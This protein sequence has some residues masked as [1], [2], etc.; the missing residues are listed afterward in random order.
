M[1]VSFEYQIQEIIHN[2]D[3]FEELT[4]NPK[5]NDELISFLREKATTT[6]IIDAY[7]VWE[8][9]AKDLI[10]QCLK[11]NRFQLVTDDFIRK[12]ATD[13]FSENGMIKEAFSN[14]I[15]KSLRLNKTYISKEV[16]CS[17]NNLNYKSLLK[18]LNRVFPT[19]KH[20]TF[21][22]F[23]RSCKDLINSTDSLTNLGIAKQE[24]PFVVDGF[25]QLIV[26]ERNSISHSHSFEHFFNYD[27]R[28]ALINF[29]NQLL[30]SLKD[31]LS[32]QLINDKIEQNI[33]HSELEITQIIK[34][35]STTEDNAI[36]TLNFKNYAG[37]SNPQNSVFYL[38]INDGEKTDKK[39]SFF[40]KAIKIKEIRNINRNKCR[41]FPKNGKRSLSFTCNHMIKTNKIYHLIEVSQMTC[42][43]SS[44]VIEEMLDN[45]K[46]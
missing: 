7:T 20:E 4:T 15:Q 32:N 34:C 35:N 12:Y 17:S 8:T 43:S 22:N 39:Q 37:N 28:V 23:L 16:I 10:F 45:T 42:D 6:A 3:F 41:V 33:Q 27:Q 30:L 44:I 38:K 9:N 29:I 46:N 19:L 25:L 36:I 11:E 2:N 14:S 21:D 5:N 40:Y 18:I 1:T 24:A 31:F 26:S 13:I